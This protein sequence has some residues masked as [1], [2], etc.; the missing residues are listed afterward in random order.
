MYLFEPFLHPV[1]ARYCRFAQG[2]MKNAIRVLVADHPRLLRE[3]VLTTFSDQPDIIVDEVADEADIVAKVKETRPDFLV[4]AQ[5]KLGER[6]GICDTVLRQQPDLRI[7]V[8][9]P[10]HNHSVFYWASINIHSRDVEAS[11]EALLG[12]LRAK[13]GPIG[14]R[15]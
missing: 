2:E 8:I 15:M 10:H 6:P 5:K 7:I 13:S 11:E 4:I 12:V 3:L 1:F 14:Y 9:A